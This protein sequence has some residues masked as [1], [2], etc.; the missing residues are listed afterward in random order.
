MKYSDM[1]DN[2]ESLPEVSV[3]E[4]DGEFFVKENAEAALAYAFNMNTFIPVTLREGKADNKKY[5][6]MKESL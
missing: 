5:V 6:K 4:C 2:G 1:L 3:F